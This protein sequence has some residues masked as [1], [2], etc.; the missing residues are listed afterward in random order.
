MPGPQATP[1][2]SEGPITWTTMQSKPNECVPLLVIR[3]VVWGLGGSFPVAKYT[4]IEN[5]K[6]GGKP[7]NNGWVTNMQR[8]STNKPPFV[9]LSSVGMYVYF[10]SWF[11]VVVVSWAYH[12]C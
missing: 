12:T 3:T 5:E 7:T 6:N 10:Q 9:L 11:E 2:P 8:R 1:W 4:N